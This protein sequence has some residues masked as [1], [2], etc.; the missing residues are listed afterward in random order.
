MKA[1][2]GR[3]SPRPRKLFHRRRVGQDL[4]GLDQPVP[5]LRRNE[6]GRRPTVSTDLKHFAGFFRRPEKRE[7]G[8]LG[9]GRSHVFH[10]MAIIVAIRST[11]LSIVAT[12]SFRRLPD[13]FPAASPAKRSD[14][15][16]P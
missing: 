11:P 5:L 15:R 2:G 16:R 3:L 8:I 7:K 4:Q 9:L 6:D 14:S 1:A 10:W 13:R 12:H